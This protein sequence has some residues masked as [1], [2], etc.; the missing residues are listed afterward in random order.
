MSR[1]VLEHPAFKKYLN[2]E[3]CIQKDFEISWGF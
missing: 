2:P 1:G 3:C